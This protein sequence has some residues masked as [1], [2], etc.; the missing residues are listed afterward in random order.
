MGADLYFY[1]FLLYVLAVQH[2]G[3]KVLM[4]EKERSIELLFEFNAILL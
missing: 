2:V 4:K 1:I 3:R